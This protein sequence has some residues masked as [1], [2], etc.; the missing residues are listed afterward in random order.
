LSLLVEAV[1]SVRYEDNR[2]GYISRLLV[3]MD[4]VLRYETGEK[5]VNEVDF[6]SQGVKLISRVSATMTKA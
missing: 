2:C 3:R 4:A 6:I 5:K 1:V